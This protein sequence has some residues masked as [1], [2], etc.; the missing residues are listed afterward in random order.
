MMMISCQSLLPVGGLLGT[1]SSGFMFVI[2]KVLGICECLTM[3][4]L[5]EFYSFHA[6]GGS[7]DF[8]SCSYFKRNYLGYWVPYGFVWRAR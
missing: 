3:D 7:C 8:N 5:L 2:Y 6:F 4:S 1:I